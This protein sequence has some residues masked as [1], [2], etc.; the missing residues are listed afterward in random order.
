MG[1]GFSLNSRRGSS[2]SPVSADVVN[3]AVGVPASSSAEA[4]SQGF[5]ANALSLP[6][7]TI[8]GMEWAC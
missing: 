7:P 4:L 8:I 3:I 6:I 2:R 1:A 5:P